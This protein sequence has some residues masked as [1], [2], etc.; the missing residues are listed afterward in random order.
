MISPA[1]TVS[2]LEVIEIVSSFS[3]GI[4]LSQLHEAVVKR[5]GPL[6][7]FHTSSRV[8]LDFDDLLVFLEARHQV[9]IFKGVVFPRSARDFR[10]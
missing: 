6:A 4:R 7:R 1:I 5:F 10:A 8:G 3:K 9:R 2:G